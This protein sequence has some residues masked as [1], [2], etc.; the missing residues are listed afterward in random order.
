MIGGV[1]K[2]QSAVID[3][4]VDGITAVLILEEGQEEFL[5]PALSLPEGS[6]EGLWLLVRIEDGELVDVEIDH[7]RTAA[8]EERIRSKRAQLLQRTRRR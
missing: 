8:M 5:C 6:K 1:I 7:E 3:R 2:I 4:I